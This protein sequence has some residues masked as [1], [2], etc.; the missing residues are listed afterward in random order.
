MH[1]VQPFSISTNAQ[2]HAYVQ[3]KY[4]L[5]QALQDGVGVFYNAL[6]ACKHRAEIAGNR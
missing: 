2:G 1:A 6:N 4:T 5:V 3:A